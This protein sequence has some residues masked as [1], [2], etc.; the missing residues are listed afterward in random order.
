[1]RALPTV[2]TV[3]AL[4]TV[5]LALALLGSALPADA[6]DPVGTARREVAALRA[7]ARRATAS[8]VA[9]TERLEADRARLTAVER[10]ATSARR[11]AAQAQTQVAGSRERLGV[12][13]AAAYRRP[14]PD[15]VVLALG[16]GA[17][18]LHDALVARADLDHV[19][20]DEQSL[21]RAASGAS[22][23]A[24]G[25][26]RSAAQLE[27]EAR[28]RSR[29]VAR[30]VA[31]LRAQAERSRQRLQRAADRLARAQ[32]EREAAR[33][34]AARL[35][36]A[37]AAPDDPSA[38]ACGGGGTGGAPNGFLPA[39]SLCPIGGGH[40]LRADAAAAFLRL[41]AA[42]PQCVTDAYRSYGGQVWVYRRTPSLAAVPGTSK[43]GL[44][45]ALDLGCGAERFGSDAYRWLQ[46]NAGRFGWH[47]PAWAEPGGVTPEPWHWEYGG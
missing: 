12:V 18:A 21:L 22:V 26:V 27:Q 11:E 17:Q 47:H 44:G 15:D 35:R 7:D 24:R 34:R 25:L 43:H 40:A 39:T 23:R 19:R 33:L 1:M 20:G 31:R 36:A 38:A 29:A 16:S 14:A 9:G 5:V 28:A 8:L 3:R 46:A 37:S 41:H 45:I 32:A 42:R 2:A 30:D 13:V 4:P 10:H 6:A